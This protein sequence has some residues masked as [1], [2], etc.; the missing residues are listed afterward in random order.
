MRGAITALTAV[1]MLL[2]LVA[3]PRAQSGDSVEWHAAFAEDAAYF[4]AL[5]S[6]DRQATIELDAATYVYRRLAASGLRPRLQLM[7]DTPVG[8]TDSAIVE[9]TVPGVRPDSLLIAVPL[10]LPAAAPSEATD[11]EHADGTALAL[12]LGFARLL[13]SAPQPPPLSVRFLF[14]GAERGDPDLGYPFGSRRFLQGFPASTSTAVLYVD[15]AGL[16]EVLELRTGGDAV[17]AP[18]WLI[19][20]VSAA[21]HT[22]GQPVRMPP[23]HAHFLVRLGLQREPALAPFYRAGHP[24]LLLTSHKEAQGEP[25]GTGTSPDLW[26][27][28]MARFL[29]LLLAEFG[30]G[31]PETWDRNYL[32]LG[33][34]AS[35][36]IMPE[37]E[38]VALV[39]AAIALVIGYAFAA[40]RQLRHAAATLR[41]NAWRIVPMAAVAAGSL[42]AGSA[43]IALLVSVQESPVLWEQSPLL[44]LTLKLGFAALVATLARYVVSS[45]SGGARREPI[46]GFYV[47]GA[48]LLLTGLVALAAA[49]HVAL[50]YPFLWALLCVLLANL[51]RNRW[52]QL[53]WI[54]LAPVWIIRIA[55]GLFL[56]PDLPFVALALFAPLSIDLLAGAVLLPLF[57]LAR[58]VAVSFA[59]YRPVRPVY[60]Q[61]LRLRLAAAVLVALLGVG[62]AV[63]VSL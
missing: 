39:V 18:P 54:I 36:L 13:A 14:L 35:L 21:L 37:Y 4:T 20:R 1:G 30:S 50:A 57:L 48:A 45:R 3:T 47:A 26:L 22:A 8:G 24:A 28:R 32:L 38:Y 7:T 63:A 58:G 31:T 16:P 5:R 33:G 2:A 19:S 59:R 42:A 43:G 46:A 53:L 44:F 61:Q 25:V 17:V 15:L 12:V 56:Q 60:R 6:P 52:I 40:S 23:A 9:A 29:A 41:Q 10:A 34:T 62:S 55:G 51:A 49:V 27:A 11:D